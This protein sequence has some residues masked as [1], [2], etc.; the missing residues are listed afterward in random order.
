MNGGVSNSESKSKAARIAGRSRP[1]R[2]SGVAWIGE[3]PEGWK[4]NRG[5]Y[6]LSLLARPVLPGEGVMFLRSQNVYD[7]GLYLDDVM[8]ISSDIDSSMPGSR[9]QK[10]DVLLNITGGSIGRACVYELSASANV[11]QHVCIIRTTEKCITAY[12][13]Y[14]LNGH[15]SAIVNNNQEGGNRESLNFEQIG[16]LRLPLPPLSEQREI[17]AYLDEKCGAIDAMVEKCRGELE[18]L[19]EY[20]KSLIFECVTGK[21]AVA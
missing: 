4:V 3:V 10:G 12:L 21:R 2:D 6:E 8:Y 15:K 19:A 9:V 1:M 17:A 16:N 7:E 13:R 18:K 14:F 20:K 5:K 11:N